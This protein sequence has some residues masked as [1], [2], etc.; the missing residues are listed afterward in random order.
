MSFFDKRIF[1]SLLSLKWKSLSVK[2]GLPS[3][4]FTKS[5]AI[6]DCQSISIA[7]ASIGHEI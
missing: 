6:S 3:P 4:T 1:V 5:S 2:V 7:S